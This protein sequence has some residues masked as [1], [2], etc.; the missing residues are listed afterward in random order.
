MYVINICK[1][2][3]SLYSNRLYKYRHTVTYTPYV[4]FF[5]FVYSAQADREHHHSNA[6]DGSRS[7]SHMLFDGTSSWTFIA[8]W[9]EHLDGAPVVGEFLFLGFRPFIDFDWTLYPFCDCFALPLVWID[10]VLDFSLWCKNGLLTEQIEEVDCV[11]QIP[12]FHQA[13]GIYGD[14]GVSSLHWRMLTGQLWPG[15]RRPP[16]LG[17]FRLHEK[18]KALFKR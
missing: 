9:S 7:R 16:N 13:W 15:V 1:R 12:L 6:V 2:T 14:L 4:Y 5:S 17:C 10:T 11:V 3:M 18:R 8:Y